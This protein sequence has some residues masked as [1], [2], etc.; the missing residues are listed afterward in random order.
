LGGKGGYLSVYFTPTIIRFAI[1]DSYPLPKH[2]KTINP[3]II[4]KGR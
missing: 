4:E 1:T 2:S 3:S